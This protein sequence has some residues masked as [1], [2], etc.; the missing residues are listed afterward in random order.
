MPANE[1]IHWNWRNNCIKKQYGTSPKCSNFTTMN[2]SY[3]SQPFL[4]KNIHIVWNLNHSF[5]HDSQR[6]LYRVCLTQSLLAKEAKPR[7]PLRISSEVT[8]NPAE[9]PRPFRYRYIVIFHRNMKSVRDFN[10]P[11]TP[12]SVF[13]FGVSAHIETGETGSHAVMSYQPDVQTSRPWSSRNHIIW[14][15]STAYRTKSKVF[16]S[17]WVFCTET[18][19]SIAWTSKTK[20]S[21]S[22]SVCVW[23][24]RS[25][26]T[27]SAP[28]WPPS[29][30]RGS[31]SALRFLQPP[32]SSIHVL[33]FCILRIW[34]PWLHNG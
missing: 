9:R 10:H 12:V 27:P 19:C 6:S 16:L 5:Q 23:A 1:C 34:V 8:F 13:P 33:T 2:S 32:S 22:R 30:F 14:R 4:S 25:R 11:S 26:S 18:R 31:S 28:A 17:R 15:T 20:E 24:P 21:N 29:P 7:K 3:S